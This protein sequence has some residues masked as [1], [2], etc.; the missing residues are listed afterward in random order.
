MNPGTTHC[1]ASSLGSARPLSG[2]QFLIWEMEAML[3]P[4]AEGRSWGGALCPAPLLGQE[5][6][7]WGT[8]TQRATGVWSSG[9]RP[10]N[11]CVAGLQRALGRVVERA[12]EWLPKEGER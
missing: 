8:G 3:V 7:H 9:G 5:G 11:C 6:A 1:C 12:S 4:A 10:R 2:P